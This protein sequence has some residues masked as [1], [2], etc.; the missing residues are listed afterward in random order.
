[1]CHRV[2][3]LPRA[4]AKRLRLLWRVYSSNANAVLLL[5]WGEDGERVTISDVDHLAGE[6][7]GVR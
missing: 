1:M 2:K 4:V 6:F 7:I 3:V 5:V